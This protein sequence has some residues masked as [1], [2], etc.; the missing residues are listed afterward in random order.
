MTI[1]ELEQELLKLS[2]P[3]KKQLIKRL[4]ADLDEGQDENVELVWLEEAQRRYKEL[5]DG[6][7]KAVPATIAI[8]KARERLG[9][10]H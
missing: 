9:N 5:K 3:E 4:I 8:A 7:V 6:V 10:V 1:K 2:S